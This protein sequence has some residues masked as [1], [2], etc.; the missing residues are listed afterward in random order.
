MCV[1]HNSEYDWSMCHVLVLF[2][3]NSFDLWTP[4]LAEMAH[5]HH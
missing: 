1:I 2:F 4:S 5:K 3:I